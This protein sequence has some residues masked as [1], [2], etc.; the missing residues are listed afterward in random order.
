MSNSEFEYESIPVGYYDKMFTEGQKVNRGLQ[1]SWHYLKFKTVKSHFPDYK[2]HSDI[3]CGPGTFIGNFLDD[4][5]I[6]LDISHNQISYAKNT[7]GSLS[8]QFYLKDMNKEFN[9]EKKYDVITLLEFIEHITPEEVNSLILKCMNKLNENGKIII[10]TPN[11]RGLWLFLEKIVSLVG[12]VDY[13][14][15]H[16]NRYTKKR[17]EK[18]L[19]FENLA[20]QKYINFGIFLSFIDTHLGIKAHEIVSKIFKNFFGYSL[21]IT[22]EK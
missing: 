20:V 16:I 4:R 3:A 10:T 18:E 14:L 22:I 9:D 8:N 1:F 7:Y 13:K 17:I 5:S 2:S 19:N 12:P 6:G 11:Y 21:L 15:Q